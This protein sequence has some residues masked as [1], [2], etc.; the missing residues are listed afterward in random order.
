ML[1]FN[2][3]CTNE[4]GSPLSEVYLRDLDLV[5]KCMVMFERHEK[6][7]LRSKILAFNSHADHLDMRRFSSAGKLRSESRIRTDQFCARH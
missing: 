6:R 2:M 5:A 7:L 1:Y 4:P 3:I